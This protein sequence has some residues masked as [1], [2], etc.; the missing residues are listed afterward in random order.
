MYTHSQC[1]SLC[2]LHISV[3]E[4]LYCVFYFSFM[5]YCPSS[6]A[7]RHF[8]LRFLSFISGHKV[9]LEFRIEFETELIDFD[10]WCENAEM[11]AFQLISR[12]QKQNWTCLL[13]RALKC[14]VSTNDL[15]YDISHLHSVAYSLIYDQ[16]LIIPSRNMA[17]FRFNFDFYNWPKMVK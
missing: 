6:A 2:M 16:A 10:R 5:D 9:I 14:T 11:C 7:C 12:Q 13:S 15:F 17:F 4:N 1:A 8:L 3:H